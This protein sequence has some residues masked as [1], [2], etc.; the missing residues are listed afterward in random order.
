MKIIQ[1]GENERESDRERVKEKRQ[2]E[3]EMEK[4][5]DKKIWSTRGYSERWIKKG[6]R[7]RRR[8]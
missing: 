4:K 2:I 7:E 5:V 3:R 8:D 1:K 6:D